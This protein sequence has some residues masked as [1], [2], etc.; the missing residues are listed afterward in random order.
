MKDDPRTG[1]PSENM[2]F[3]RINAS[4]LGLTIGSVSS[5]VVR[6]ITFRDC[7]LRATVKGLYLKFAR[8]VNSSADIGHVSDITY[9]NIYLD[10]VQQW[11]IWIGPAQQADASNRAHAPSPT[12]IRFRAILCIPSC[13]T[14]LCYTCSLL[15]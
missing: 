4:G 8:P 1:A 6:N 5:G 13:A 12:L 15:V 7:Y 3:E 9:E 2:L 10:A 11:P 14:L